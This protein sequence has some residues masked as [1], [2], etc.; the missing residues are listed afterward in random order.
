MK[1]IVLLVAFLSA[2]FISVRAQSEHYYYYQ[3]N[4]IYLNLDLKRIS[5]N[6]FTED[7]S[8]LDRVL[9]DN[10]SVSDVVPQYGVNPAIY[11]FEIEFSNSLT[12]VNYHSIINSINTHISIKKTSPTYKINEHKLGCTN[13]FYVKLKRSDDIYVLDQYVNNFNLEIQQQD[14]Y[15][16][17]WY[18]ISTSKEH[19]NSLQLSNIFYESGLFET[20]EPE[21]IGQMVEFSNNPFFGDQWD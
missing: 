8:F 21:F 11:Y 18:V 19:E 12:E 17:L 6:S 9:S 14:K 10:F 3:G 16:P 15:M 4:K 20:A 1:K 2:T 5:V 13:S 7:V